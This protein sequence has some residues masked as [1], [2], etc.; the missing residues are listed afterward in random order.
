MAS[1]CEVLVDTDDPAQAAAV[2]R[3]RASRGR[4]HRGEVQPLPRRHRSSGGSTP[5]AAGPSSVDDETAQLLDYAAELPSSSR[6]AAST[7]PRAS[8]SRLDVRRRQPRAR[9]ESAARG[10]AA[11]R[12]LDDGGAGA[13]ARSRC[14]PGMEIDLGGIGKEYAVDRAAALVAAAAQRRVPGQLRRRPVRRRT[15]PGRSAW[16]VGVDDPE[17]AGRSAAARA[18]SSAAAGSRPAATR[19][20]SCAIAGRRLGHILDPTTGWPVE[21][22]P[23]SV[24]V[25]AATCL[26]AGTLRDARLSA[27]RGRARVPRG[28]RACGTGSSR[29]AA[30]PRP[31][32]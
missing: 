27:R 5:R 32:R 9:R 2:G 25:L 16:T 31:A 14:P 30:R 22:A 3:D 12:R 28:A 1:P 7:S 13:S 15:A 26:E 19:G 6:K 21:G 8:A 23:K 11:T 10:R 24:T 17:R 18:S 29:R 20:A 4:A